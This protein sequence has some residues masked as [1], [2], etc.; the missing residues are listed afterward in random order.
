MK[1]IGKLKSNV[2]TPVCVSSI[3][4]ASFVCSGG[5]MFARAF[6]YTVQPLV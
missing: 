2:D 4:H 1:Y 6:L 5:E 3:A